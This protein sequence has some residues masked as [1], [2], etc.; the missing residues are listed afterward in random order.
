MNKDVSIKIFVSHRIDLKTKTLNNKY[1]IPVRCGAVFDKSK[2]NII[3]DNTGEN[4]SEK[5]MSYCELTV[6]YWAWKNEKAD[7]MGLCHYRRFFDFTKQKGIIGTTVSDN[8]CIIANYLTPKTIKKFGLDEKSVFDGTANYDAV[9]VNPI[10]FENLGISSNYDAMQ[11]CPEYHNMRDVD[12]TLEI[13][14][15]KSPDIYD[16]A[17]EYFYN[18]KYSRAYN[19]FIMKYELFNKYCTWLFE[20]L[21]ELEK[22][23]DMTNYSGLL[24]RTPGTI[25]ERLTGIWILWLQ[26]QK[27]LINEVPLLFI[28]Y[29]AV[30]DNKVITY[31]G[32]YKTRILYH[33]TNDVKKRELYKAKKIM[34]KQKINAIKKQ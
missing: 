33:L 14:K 15:E 18:I 22:R 3:G 31:L 25:S 11:K 7:Y 10:F 30:Y 24:L 1:Y 19:C 23:I 2:S 26:K 4:I 12:I 5:R 29:P 32:Y 21:T 20:I 27:Y 8:G 17:L 28:K 6:L 34:L 16:V 13:I 9:I